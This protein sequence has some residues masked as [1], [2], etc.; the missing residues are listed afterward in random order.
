M[1]IFSSFNNV[2]LLHS[3]FAIV[4]MPQSWGWGTMAAVVQRWLS[5]F[6][7]FLQSASMVVVFCV[8]NVLIPA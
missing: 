5:L 7:V 8:T 2:A 3:T 1:I 6:I 4:S